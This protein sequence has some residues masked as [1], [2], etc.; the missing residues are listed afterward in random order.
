MKIRM[1]YPMKLPKTKFTKY[2]L[3]LFGLL[4]GFNLLFAK[5]E[6]PKYT[7][8]LNDYADV[9]EPSEERMLNRLLSDFQDSVGVQIAVVLE[10]NSEYDA[11]D[12]GMF[13]SRAWQIGDKGVNNGILVYLNIGGRKYHIITADKTQGKLTDGIVGDIGR[14]SLVPYLKTGDYYNAVRETVYA[15]AIAVKGEFKGRNKSNKKSESVLSVLA[16][17]LLFLLFYLLFVRR[18]GCGGYSRRGFCTPPIF[19]GGSGF[20]GGFGGGGSSGGFGGFGG[21]GGFNGGGAGGS[22]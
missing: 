1:N 11:F 15:L 18:G 14:N 12:R 2:V 20:G 4:A 17:I 7:N 6:V 10:A 19:F 13:I 22:W 8:F 3:L 21:G 5:Q 16:P 9:L